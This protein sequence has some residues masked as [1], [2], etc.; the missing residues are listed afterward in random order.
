[1]FALVGRYA[2]PPPPGVSP[3]P[4]WGDPRIVRERLGEAV[5]EITFDRGLMRNPILS[6]PH[7]R[8]NAELTVGPIMKLVQ[9]LS[10]TDPEKLAAF[11][12]EL[13]ELVAVY[14][15]DNVLRMDFLMTRALKR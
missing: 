5:T 7:F 14:L 12:R 9:Q 6:P 2:P 1:M 4:Q 8:A 3:P 13:D 10:A 11:R 15:T